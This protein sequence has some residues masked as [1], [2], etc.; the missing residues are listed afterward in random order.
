MNEWIG[1]SYS[2]STDIIALENI[3]SAL[4]CLNPLVADFFIFRSH[5]EFH[6]SIVMLTCGKILKKSLLSTL[7]VYDL[8]K[9]RPIFGDASNERVLYFA[10]LLFLKSR[11]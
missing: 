2:I 6:V 11:I 9:M 3:V 8:G 4:H 7:F 1:G 10:M 5:I